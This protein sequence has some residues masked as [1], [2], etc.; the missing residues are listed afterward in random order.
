[1]D[2]PS[3]KKPKNLTRISDGGQSFRT[4]T[5]I[6][7]DNKS[8]SKT[9]IEYDND[10]SLEIKEE[11]IEDQETTGENR[12]E[13][14]ETK[15]CAVYMEEDN[16]CSAE[17]KPEMKYKCEKCGR[18]YKSEA[19]LHAHQTIDCTSM[20]QYKCEYCGKQFKRKSNMSRHVRA[21][22]PRVN[23]FGLDF[24]LNKR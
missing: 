1:M 14:H 10:E 18:T 23:I 7:S 19:S 12:D 11:N 4:T 5:P 16:I 24:V 21:I 3:K 6:C 9:F 2:L 8:D 20:P 22:H 17:D 15:F 13:K